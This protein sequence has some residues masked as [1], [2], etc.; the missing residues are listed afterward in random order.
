M[1]SVESGAGRFTEFL[2]PPLT[3]AEFLRFTGA[4]TPGDEEPNAEEIAELNRRFIDYLNF[5]GFP[6]AV[7][8]DTVRRSMD[9][10]IAND[11]IDKVLLRDLP[12]LYGISDTQ[13]LNRLFATL[14][15]NTGNEVNLE[16]LSKA[17]NVAKNT[18]R[19]YLDYLEAAFLIQRLHRVDQNARRFQRVTHFK[20]YLTNPCIRV[21]LFG[22]VAA[23]D[24]AMG[25]LAETALVSQIAHSRIIDRLYYS[26]WAA[27]EVDL[28][29]IDVRSQ[30]PLAPLEIKWSDRAVDEPK[31]ELRA[32]VSFCKANRIDKAWVL[33]R[34]RFASRVVLDVALNYRPI[35]FD[36]YAAGKALVEAPI[37]AGWHPRSDTPLGGR[38]RPRAG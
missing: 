26:R 35:A 31:A 20:V 5:G 14:A 37:G 29:L 13:E 18:L 4:A 15:Y 19:K 12:S 22:A 38:R 7:M 36:C 1:R 33:V 24:E 3:F 27:G 6:E 2:L 17:S 23:D 32:L 34:S 16:E 21:A 9:R 10:Y 25:R 8:D 28:V 11:I 30:Q